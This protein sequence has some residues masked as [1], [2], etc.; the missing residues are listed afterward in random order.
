MKIKSDYF[1]GFEKI[2]W[3]SSLSLIIVFFCIF[4]RKGWLSLV[5]TLIGVNALLF[6]AKG[7]PTGQALAI[8]FS[9]LYGIISFRSR[10]Y[11]EMITYIGMTLPMAV[12]ALVSWLKNPYQK[13]KSSEVAVNRLKLKEIFFMLGLSAVVT[14]VFFFILKA[15]NTA[16]LIPSTLS[17][18]TS[19]IASYLTFRRSAYYA[20]AY[21]MNDIVLIVLWGMMTVKDISCI[22]VTVCFVLFLILDVYGFLCWH[23]ME[24][25]QKA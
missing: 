6:N 19:F 3:L 2:L 23:R 1:T 20:V 4:D 7:N 8:I 18:T 16:N 17:I 22:S 24:I 14:V 11:G 5:A 10:Y 12:V 25:R 13:G 9:I 21:A 15:F